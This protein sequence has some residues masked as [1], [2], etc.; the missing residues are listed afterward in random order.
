MFWTAECAF[1]YT[2]SVKQMD[3]T[4]VYVYFSSDIQIPLDMS[5]TKVCVEIISDYHTYKIQAK[6]KCIV[7]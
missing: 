4:D 1:Q 7:I 2:Y 3:L 6:R 5:F